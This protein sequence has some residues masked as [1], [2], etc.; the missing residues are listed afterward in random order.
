MGYYKNKFVM[1]DGQPIIPPNRVVVITPLDAGS[2]DFEKSVFD[3]YI[4]RDEFDAEQLACLLKIGGKKAWVCPISSLP[5]NYANNTS[6][7]NLI[8]GRV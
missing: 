3:F 5:T 2:K 1:Y 8:F 7:P 4:C 6:R